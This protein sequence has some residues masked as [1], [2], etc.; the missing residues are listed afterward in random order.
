[1]KWFKYET[2]YVNGSSLTAGGGLGSNDIKDEYKRL[3]N[4]EWENEKDVTYPKYVADYFN[5]KLVHKALSGSGAPRLVREVYDYIIEV[6]IEEARKTMFLLEITDPI[7]RVDLYCNE[8]DDYIIANVRYDDD[9]YELSTKISSIQIQHITTKDGRYFDYKF[10]EGKIENE[11]KEFLEKYHNPIAYTEKYYG[12]VAGLLSFLKENDITFFYMFNEHTL[13]THLNY[14]YK[15]FDEYELRVQEHNCINQFSGINKLTIKDEL[16]GFSSDV[17]PGYYGNLKFSEILIEKIKTKLEPTLFV[18]GDSHTQPFQQLF[19]S[20]MEWAVDYVNHINEKP[21]NFADIISE[22]FNDITIINAGRGGFSNYSIFEEFLK[23][24][25]KIKSK[26]ILVFGWTT[27]SRFRIAN[28][29][30]R[31]IDII[32]FNAHPKQNDDVSK[33]TTNEIGVNK[34]TY[35]IW[36]Q[37]ILNYIDIINSLFPNNLIYHWT[38]IDNETTYPTRLWSEEMLNEDYIIVVEGEW[39]SYDSEM[40][41]IIKDNS[42]ILFDLSRS[43][44]YDNIV[45]DVKSGKRVILFNYVYS[46]KQNEFLQ[47]YNFKTRALNSKNY[48]KLCFEKFIPYKKYTTIFQETNGVVNDLHT[49]KIGHQELATDLIN[50]IEKDIK[51]TNIKNNVKKSLL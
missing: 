49:S 23:N 20:K 16:N 17:H 37:E 10:F 3:Y 13:K 28:E 40:K 31:L 15:K 42:D 6:G 7:H 39:S 4:L 9:N 18:Y 50:L 27:E 33:N 45:E 35:N 44:N 34:L 24:K 8:I 51:K 43:T 14:F 48:K 19:D 46:E 5:L 2:L 41:N 30:N 47:K 22:E 36:W 25:D 11:I 29:S 12:E 1:M 38:W 26:D 21:K 32:P